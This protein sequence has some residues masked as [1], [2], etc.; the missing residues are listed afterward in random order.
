MKAEQ[1]KYFRNGEFIA[2]SPQVLWQDYQEQRRKGIVPVT[3]NGT[4]L[5][6]LLERDYQGEA[7]ILTPLSPTEIAAVLTKNGSWQDSA[8]GLPEHDR[9]V[10]LVQQDPF[11][12]E[13]YIQ[14]ASLKLHTVTGEP[15]VEFRAKEGPKIVPLSLLQDPT[16]YHVT[17]LLMAREPVENVI[18]AVQARARKEVRW[19]GVE[20][21]PNDD[22]I[23]QEQ[24]Q[25]QQIEALFNKILP[26]VTYDRGDTYA[27]IYS[28]LTLF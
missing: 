20:S 27:S 9:Q 13:E 19:V 25:V 3:V 1:I 17:G 16:Y 21:R 14:A 7:D 8:V 2:Y 12:R 15:A 18:T 4:K 11:S 26:S 6:N 10:V 23:L 22:S 24:Q 28:S 5:V